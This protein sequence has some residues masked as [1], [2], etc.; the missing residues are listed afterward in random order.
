MLQL[1]LSGKMYIIAASVCKHMNA[2]VSGRDKRELILNRWPTQSQSNSK[3]ITQLDPSHFCFLNL[4]ALLPDWMAWGIAELA[5]QELCSSHMHL[6]NLPPTPPNARLK[7]YKA[8]DNL[9]LVVSQ[10]DGKAPRVSRCARHGDPWKV[11]Q[12][13]V[14]YNQ[15]TTVTQSEAGGK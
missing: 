1:S 4:L 5:G 3:E 9:F 8:T 15:L 14:Q 2:L 6:H 7:K 10:T 13:T 12:T 11:S